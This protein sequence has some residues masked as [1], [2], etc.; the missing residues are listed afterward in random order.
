M[1]PGM[2]PRA[3]RRPDRAAPPSPRCLSRVAGSLDS[4]IASI[5][6]YAN[7]FGPPQVLLARQIAD[8]APT[9]KE[10]VLAL[11]TGWARADVDGRRTPLG[12]LPTGPAPFGR[13]LP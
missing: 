3:R 10:S 4:T 6:L 2:T 13:R 7:F 1:L 12:H 8:F 11:V 5:G 9:H